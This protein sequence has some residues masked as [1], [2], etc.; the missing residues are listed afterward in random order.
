DGDAALRTVEGVKGGCRSVSKGR[1]PAAA[2][3]APFGVLD[4]DDLC[5]ELAEDHPGIG[6][7]DA[8]T[9]LDHDGAGKRTGARHRQLLFGCILITTTVCWNRWTVGP[10]LA[11]WRRMMAITAWAAATMPG[12]AR[13]I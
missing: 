5:A 8:V 9:D 3:I 12:P 1:A 13:G 4:L 6:C 7:G 2:R 11:R 10:S